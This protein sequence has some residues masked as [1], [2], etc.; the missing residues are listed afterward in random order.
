MEGE[1]K[2]GFILTT[3]NGFLANFANSSI[4]FEQYGILTIDFHYKTNFICIKSATNIFS[5][6][7]KNAN[8]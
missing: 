4:N 2:Y 6:E 1:V 5:E 8:L 3:I 7:Q